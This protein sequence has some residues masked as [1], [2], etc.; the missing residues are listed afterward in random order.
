MYPVG[1]NCDIIYRISF[2]F[3]L[4]SFS[5]FWLVDL[6]IWSF[7]NPMNIYSMYVT[8]QESHISCPYFLPS[9]ICLFWTSFP[10]CVEKT[11]AAVTLGIYPIKMLDR[12][13]LK[14]HKSHHKPPRPTTSHHDLPRATT[15]H[16]DLPRANTTQKFI[17]FKNLRNTPSQKLRSI[18]TVI[19]QLINYKIEQV[20]CLA[21]YKIQQ[22]VGLG[23]LARVVGWSSLVNDLFCWV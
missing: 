3:R 23:L 9:L 10:F 13:S 6:E 17:H 15:S 12:S 4:Q 14:Q 21:Y 5:W 8:S 11:T 1:I 2:T 22:V 18:K 7:K 20:F 16:H 19:K